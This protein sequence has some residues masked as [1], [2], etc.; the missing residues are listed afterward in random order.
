[1]RQTEGR[2]PPRLE[3]VHRVAYPAGAIDQHIIFYEVVAVA[4]LQLMSGRLG[5]FFYIAERALHPIDQN[6]EAFVLAQNAILHSSPRE[7]TSDCRPGDAP[8]RA[9]VDRT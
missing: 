3:N 4:A 6:V 1:M 7:A 8:N 9:M 5:A 2:R